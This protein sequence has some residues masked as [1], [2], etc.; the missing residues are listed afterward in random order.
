MSLELM[1]LASNMVLVF[2]SIQLDDLMGQVFIFYILAIAAA[3]TAV[4]L[5]ILVSYYRTNHFLL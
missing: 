4:G 3:E 2:F 5:S 1:I